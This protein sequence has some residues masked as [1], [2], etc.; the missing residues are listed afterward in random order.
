MDQTLQRNSERHTASSRTQCLHRKVQHQI[1]IPHHWYKPSNNIKKLLKKAKKEKKNKDLTMSV[2]K[3]HSELPYERKKQQYRSF[4][5]SI[6]QNQIS[7]NSIQ[8]YEH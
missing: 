7:N 8:T 4:L 5:N 1:A 3:R 2:H 6:K